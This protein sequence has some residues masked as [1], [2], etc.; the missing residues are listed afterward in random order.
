MGW[1]CLRKRDRSVATPNLPL[2]ES[3]LEIKSGS[4]DAGKGH[5][6]RCRPFRCLQCGKDLE[7][8]DW[9][10]D[11]ELRVGLCSKACRINWT[12]KDILSEESVQLDPS[13]R[14]RGANWTQQANRARQRDAYSC[15]LCGVSEE[16]LGQRLHVHHNIPYRSFRT[17]VEANR[18]EHLI[19]VCPYCH[20]KLERQLR[21]ELPL[22]AKR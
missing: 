13:V 3:E 4:I 7:V 15:R 11:A 9:F 19:S 16:H 8:P 21:K 6:R 12:R 22:F 14:K 5:P 17:N 18:L 2:F 20:G 10:Q 1:V